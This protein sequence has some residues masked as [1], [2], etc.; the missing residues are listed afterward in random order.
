MICVVSQSKLSWARDPANSETVAEIVKAGF[1]MVRDHLRNE[2]VK[3]YWRELLVEYARLLQWGVEID[4][5]FG[6]VLQSKRNLSP[7]CSS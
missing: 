5:N 7:E 6:Q 3:E 4:G 1:E 2:D